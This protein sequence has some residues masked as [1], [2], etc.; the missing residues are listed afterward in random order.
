V[1]KPYHIVN[2]AARESTA[3]IEQFRRANGQILFPI[4]NLIESASRA[5]ETVMHVIGLQT[6]EQ[7]LIIS[8]AQLAGPRTLGK[9]SGAIRDHGSQPA[10]VQLTDRKLKVKWPRLCH[11]TDGEVK[12]PAYEMLRQ[13]EDSGSTCWVNALA[14][15]FAYF[16]V[17]ANC[18]CSISDFASSTRCR[19]EG[20][21]FPLSP[22]G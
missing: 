16:D 18:A 21:R 3:V 6:L 17:T 7:F 8:A 9:T 19:S 12:V 10:R 20:R 13:I 4:L 2:L 5:L 11:K 1:K 14:A 22:N 15:F